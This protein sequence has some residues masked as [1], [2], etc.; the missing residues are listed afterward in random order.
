[1]FTVILG[2]H[3]QSEDDQPQQTFGVEKVI[4]HEMFRTNMANSDIMLVKLDRPVELNEYISPVCLIDPD[5]D[6]EEGRHAYVTG[7]GQGLVYVF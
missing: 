2:L 1:M 7:W 6:I 5:I 4:P 3:S